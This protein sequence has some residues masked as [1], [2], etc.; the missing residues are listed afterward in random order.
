MS[1]REKVY[2]T[3][4]IIM[5]LLFLF[6]IPV[7]IARPQ[8][9]PVEGPQVVMRVIPGAL[10]PW[11]AVEPQDVTVVLGLVPANPEDHYAPQVGDSMLCH[12]YTPDGTHYGY[13][14]GN[15]RYLITHFD[16]F[17]KHKPKKERNSK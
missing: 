11:L 8:E 10:G 9:K 12:A 2:L 5:I 4:F 3:L 6:S 14:C 7:K 13:R 16:V 15:D 17:P 1:R